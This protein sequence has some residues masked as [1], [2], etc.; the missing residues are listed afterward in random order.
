MVRIITATI[1]TLGG[2]FAA[3]AAIT[4]APRSLYS[5]IDLKTCTQIAKRP[6]GGA[7]RCNGLAGYPVYVAESD[8]HQ[9]VSFG[10]NAESRRAAKQTLRASN[11]IFATFHARATIEW[12]FDRRGDVAIPYATIVRYYT[13]SN[14]DKGEVLVVSRV[15]DKETCHVAYIDA[16]ASAEAI[17]LAR[18]VADEKARRFNCA[19]EP[20]VEGARGQSPI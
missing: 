10:S 20:R 1:A 17:S 11:T 13:S 7:W 4:I 19:W 15:T 6:D 9:F 3:I 2:T 14:N 18:K 5:T 16:L 8:L 12:R